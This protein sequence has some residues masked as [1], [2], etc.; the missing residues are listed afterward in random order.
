MYSIKM[1]AKKRKNDIFKKFRVWLYIRS[2]I[3]CTNNVLKVIKSQNSKPIPI[4]NSTV[5]V[6]TYLK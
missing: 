5:N 3:N 6:T 2:L 4:H 1:F